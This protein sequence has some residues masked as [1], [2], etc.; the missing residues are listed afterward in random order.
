[1]KKLLALAFLVAACD[2]PTVPDRLARDLYRY[3]LATPE[4]RVMRWP[5]GKVVNVYVVEHTEAARTDA[6]RAA[7]ANAIDVWNSAVLFGEVQL[8][9]TRNVNDADVVLNFSGTVLPVSISECT[10]SGSDAY[11]TFCLTEDEEHLTVFPLLGDEVG[12]VKFLVTIRTISPLNPAN[13]TR[14]VAHEM[15][16]VLGLAQHSALSTDV[17][18]ELAAVAT[19]PTLR[20][21]A[22][23]QALYH[24]PA[25]ITP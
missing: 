20:D 15:G 13:V 10:P 8:R 23:L 17:M 19:R 12:Q 21:R 1:M 18:H 5:V 9:E 2:S 3:E 11:T 25:E 14:L 7:L 16:H 22:T 4:L 24:T 6:L